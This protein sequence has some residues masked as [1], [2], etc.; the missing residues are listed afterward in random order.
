[1]AISG[2]VGMAIMDPDIE[3]VRY[4]PPKLEK[5]EP[6]EWDERVRERRRVGRRGEMKRLGDE[7]E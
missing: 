3:P 2:A 1:M 5:D 4:M 7:G 6:V